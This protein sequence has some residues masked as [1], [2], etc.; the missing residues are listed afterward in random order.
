MYTG[1]AAGGTLATGKYQLALYLWFAGVDP[2]DSSQFLCSTR[3]PAGYNQSRYCNAQM[4]AA[5]R[6]AL[7]SFDRSRRIA[8]YARVEDLLARDV[9][10]DFLFWQRNVQAINPDFHGFDPNPVNETWDA[11]RWSI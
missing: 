11:Y 1:Y 7:G 5:Q 9:P 4:D 8:A 2:D 6:E 3:E 10:L